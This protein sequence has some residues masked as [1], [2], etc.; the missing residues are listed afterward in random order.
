[1][2]NLRFKQKH[3]DDPNLYYYIPEDGFIITDRAYITGYCEEYGIIEKIQKNEE[4]YFDFSKSIIDI[5][6]EDGNYAMLLDFSHNYCFEPNKR[7]CALL[8]ANTFLKNKVYTTDVYNVALGDEEGVV[9]FNNFC[10]EGSGG[11]EENS[12]TGFC[13]DKYEVPMKILDSYNIENVGLIK[14]D[15]EG[16]E[17]KVLRGAVETIKR[18]NYPPIL[19]E[20]WDVGYWNMTQ[21][22]HDSLF[23]FIKSLGYEIIEHWGNH[24]THLAIYKERT[25][26]DDDTTNNK[27]DDGVVL[28]KGF[29]LVIPLYNKAKVVRD[30]LDSVLKNHGTYPFRCLIIDDDSTDGSSEIGEEYCMKYPDVF[31]YIKR[32]HVE[33]HKTPSFARNLGIKLAETKYI[34]FLDADDELCEGF[35][36]RACGFLDEHPEYTLYTC[37]HICNHGN[38]EYTSQI[39]TGGN[40]HDF[41]S[42]VL[43]SGLGVSFCGHVYKTE[44]VKQCLFCDY[45][46][47]DHIF[48]LMYVYYNSPIYFDNTTCQ[49]IVY[50]ICYRDTQNWA[51]YKNEDDEKELSGI[52]RLFKRLR[53]IIPGFNYNCITKEDGKIFLYKLEQ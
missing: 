30:T 11:L 29:T 6:A 22:K 45:P 23:N 49:S 21:E 8:Y 35:I 17:E 43:N 47:E 16:F 19:F 4:G 27:T 34:G 36:D 18:S 2:S 9:N 3:Q 20:G 1:M 26:N 5:G 51:T 33:E 48:Q 14:V 12:N 24:E 41:E 40:V 42:Y 52:E 13:Q 50:N 32:K 28:E 53:G 39:I 7:S 31:T 15:V 38:G 46:S 44:L 25:E 10:C 37:G